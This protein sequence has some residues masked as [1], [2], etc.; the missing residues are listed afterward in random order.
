MRAAVDGKLR[1][2]RSIDAGRNWQPLTFGLPQQ[3][4]YV[5]VLRDAMDSDSLHP[6]GVYF[7]TTSGHL[8]ATRDGGER[9]EQI[10]AFL[11]RILSVK[12]AVVQR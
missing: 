9:W 3:H 7:G 8:F 6:C 10:A 11:P 5:S 2:Y 4:A 1:V 12:A